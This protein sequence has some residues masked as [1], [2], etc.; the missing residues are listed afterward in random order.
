MDGASILHNGLGH[1]DEAVVAAK[2][3]TEEGQGP[4]FTPW[5]LPELIEAA[6]RT[7]DLALADDA[8]R[9][10]SEGTIHGSDWATGL[11]AR[12]RAG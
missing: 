12:S 8:I 7:G 6:V 1:Y 3:A 9:R 2:S 11:P 4:I 5:V 10:L